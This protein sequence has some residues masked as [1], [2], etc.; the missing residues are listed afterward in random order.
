MER[1]DGD[2]LVLFA[3][4]GARNVFSSRGAGGHTVGRRRG[5]RVRRSVGADE[6]GAQLVEFALVLPILASLLL[7]IVTAGLALNSNNSLNNAARESARYGATLPVDPTM[8]GWLD[9][10][11]DVAKD[12]AT[13]DLND[14]VAGRTICVAYVYPNGS[15]ALDSTARLMIDAAGT[16]TYANGATCFADGRPDDER[17]VQVNV[18]RDADLLTI[19]FNTTLD[20]DARSVSR[21]ERAP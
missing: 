16:P 18:E 17:R 5:R 6:K 20:L 8:S 2:P 13:G 9:D 10:L 11:A 21:F 4:E 12:S 14:G 15:D 1:K 7:G 19:F 3:L